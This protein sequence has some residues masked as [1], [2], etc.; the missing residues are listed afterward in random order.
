M[1]QFIPKDEMALF[2]GTT[3]IDC[4]RQGKQSSLAQITVRTAAPFPERSACSGKHMEGSA[5]SHQ[6]PA[7]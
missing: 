5:G 7:F 2:R 4:F 3:L 6:P 1:R